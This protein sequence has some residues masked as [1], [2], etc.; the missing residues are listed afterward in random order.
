TQTASPST[1]RRPPSHPAQRNKCHRSARPLFAPTPPLALP[2]PP[3]RPR[4]PIASSQPSSLCH[5]HV[6]KGGAGVNRLAI[7]TGRPSSA[8]RRMPRQISSTCSACSPVQCCTAPAR[9][10]SAISN[11]A[12]PHST[13][14]CGSR[15]YGTGVHCRVSLLK[16]STTPLKSWL[17]L[18][19]SDP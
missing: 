9:S 5:C 8:E 2:P 6:H 14:L 4:P 15:T 18:R 10:T 12:R 11:T 1:H 7:S 17:L 19:K 16:C 13:P 3:A